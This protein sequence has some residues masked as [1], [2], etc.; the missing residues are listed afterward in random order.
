MGWVRPPR[1][2]VD[3]SCDDAVAIRVSRA[4]IKTSLDNQLP[5]DVEL[6]PLNGSAIGWDDFFVRF[7]IVQ[8]VNR[9]N[10]EHFVGE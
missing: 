6:P 4:F 10:E 1:R 9:G 5:L 3:H 2:Q 8:Q 7:D